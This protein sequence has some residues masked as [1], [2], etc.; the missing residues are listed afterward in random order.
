MSVSSFIGPSDFSRPAATRGRQPTCS[1]YRSGRLQAGVEGRDFRPSQGGD[2]VEAGGRG[3][4]IRWKRGGLTSRP[5]AI[6]PVPVP[7][8]VSSYRST[9][10]P[11]H[12]SSPT[13]KAGLLTRRRKQPAVI[14]TVGPPGHGA[15][16]VSAPGATPPH[17]F[18]ITRTTLPTMCLSCWGRQRKCRSGRR[19]ACGVRRGRSR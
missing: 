19:T 1:H 11:G 2:A 17:A 5:G 9:L 6:L 15:A 13:E 8:P 16:F 14:G 3:D 4:V 12:A 10:Q 7:P 18:L